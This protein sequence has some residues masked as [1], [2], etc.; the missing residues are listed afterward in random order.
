MDNRIEEL[1]KEILTLK[2]HIS[3]LISNI[4][5]ELDQAG[6]GK[7]VDNQDELIQR[8]EELEE[9][10]RVIRELEADFDKQLAMI[11]SVIAS[12]E[13]EVDTVELYT[14]KSE[15]IEKLKKDIEENQNKREKLLQSIEEKIKQ[16]TE[17]VNKR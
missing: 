17:E 7:L 3:G 6:Y 10:H 4:D 12:L 11:D 13:D 8:Q 5:R 9:K 16:L 1:K 15:K 14:F 2:K